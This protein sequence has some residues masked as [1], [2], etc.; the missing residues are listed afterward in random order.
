MA[1]ILTAWLLQRSGGE[2]WLI[3]VCIALLAG[4]TAGSVMA[5]IETAPQVAGR[6]AEEKFEQ[7]TLTTNVGV[8]KPAERR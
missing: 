6:R 7:A 2:P 4:V 3:A 5:L 8:A 1:S